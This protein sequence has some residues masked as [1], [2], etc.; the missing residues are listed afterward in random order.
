MLATASLADLNSRKSLGRAYLES[1]KIEDALKVYSR[2][3][4]DY[5]EDV[6][7]YLFLGDC[8][9][10]EGDAEAAL[11]LYS[12]ALEYDQ[13]NADVHM[14]IQLARTECSQ[15]FKQSQEHVDHNLVIDTPLPSD[16]KSLAGILQN[17]TGPAETVTEEDVFRAARLLE[18]IVH[19]SQPAMAVAERLDE[20]DA[21]VPALL[22]LNIRQA[23]L[24]GR[25]DLAQA[26][27]NLLDNMQLQLYKNEPPVQAQPPVSTPV[28][29]ATSKTRVLFVGD[30]PER[31]GLRQGTFTAALREFDCDVSFAAEFPFDRLNAF[32]VVVAQNPHV[33]ISTMEG[34]AACTAAKK[35]LILYLDVDY[36]QMPVDHPD[37]ETRG[38]ATPA[39]A[40][41]YSAALLLADMIFVPSQVLASTLKARGHHVQV[42][43]EG[44][45]ADSEQW[46]KPTAVRHTLNLGWIGAGGQVED[47]FQIRRMVV[48]VMRE[49]AHLRLVIGGDPAVYQLFDSLPEARRLYLPS[50]TPEDYPY[51]ISQMDILIAPL[52]NTP[53]NRSL[54]DRRLLESGLRGIP[55]VA[56]PIPPFMEWNVGGLVANTPD[57]WHT[58]LRQLVLD[59][60]LRITLGWTGHEMAKSRDAAHLGKMWSEA[61][62]GVI[63]SARG[64]R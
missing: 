21:L 3:L 41:A 17:L 23:R 12:H 27:Q 14:R 30:S 48:R 43:P 26:L 46:E 2:I 54:S 32:D 18:E 52:R 15:Q 44:W 50:V 39:R 1:N 10:A 47:V 55:W 63:K 22:E 31:Q 42:I 19:H 38:I 49:F 56:S 57:E 61:I 9:L 53:F 62:R 59:A 45:V 36:E 13:E 34:L 8:Y 51:V 58:H 40:R 35:P 5:P 33:N 6:E 28:R 16:P 4:R 25:P 29:A 37:Y 64:H 20:I 11:M 60:N 7:A 24:D